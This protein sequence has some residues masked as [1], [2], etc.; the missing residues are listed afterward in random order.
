MKFILVKVVM[1]SSHQGMILSLV[2]LSLQSKHDANKI[3]EYVFKH[4]GEEIKRCSIER[5]CCGQSFPILYD[6]L[7]TQFPDLPKIINTDLEEP[8]AVIS[9]QISKAAF[10]DDDELSKHTIKLFVQ[11]MGSATGDLG[12]NFLPYG[13]I[14]LV[15]GVTHALADYI[16]NSEH[17]LVIEFADFNRKQ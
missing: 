1:L 7:H 10:E 2:Q 14:Y 16:E 13:G 6:Y 12:A 8:V 11:I 3:R 4:K 9:K 15:G 17:F 5:V